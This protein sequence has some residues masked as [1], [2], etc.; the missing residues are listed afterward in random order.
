LECQ[1]TRIP[2]ELVCANTFDD[3]GTPATLCVKLFALDGGS[4]NTGDDLTALGFPPTPV[5]PEAQVCDTN[6][7]LCVNRKAEGDVCAVNEDCG[8]GLRCLSNGSSLVCTT[9][10]DTD[11]PCGVDS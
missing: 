11:G 6:Q 10:S 7:N 8:P 2:P 5:C 4:C 3:A 1:R 9:Y